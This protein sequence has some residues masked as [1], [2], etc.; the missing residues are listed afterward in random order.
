M[1]GAN[2]RRAIL[3]NFEGYQRSSPGADRQRRVRAIA[4]GH[5]RRAARFRFDLRQAWRADF[6]RFLDE[7]HHA[8]RMGLQKLEKAGQRDMGGPGRRATVSVFARDVLGGRLTARFNWRGGVHFPRRW[9][10][11]IACATKFTRIFTQHSGIPKLKSF[12]QY[13]GAKTVDAA[14]LAAAAGQI[15]QS[16]GSALE[17]HA[18][19]H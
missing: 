2:C 10:A 4:T 12:V 8:H 13:R 7:Y 16:D 9:S 3:N 18:A 5:L 15:H 19:S 17:I 1:A 11:G 6:L 14:S